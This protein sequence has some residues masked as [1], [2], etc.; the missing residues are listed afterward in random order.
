MTVLLEQVMP[1]GVTTELLDEVTDQMGVDQNPPQGFIVH[2]HFMRAGRA[3]IVDV[4]ASQEAYETFRQERLMPAL[5][6]VAE[7]RGVTLEEQPLTTFTEVAR[8]VTG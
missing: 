4:W 1:E 7:S 5:G 6:K 8:V 3:H 2:V